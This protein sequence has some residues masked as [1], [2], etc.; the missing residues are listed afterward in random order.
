MELLIYFLGIVVFAFILFIVRK[1]AF[2]Q[3]FSALFVLFQIGFA[4]FLYNNPNHYWSDYFHDDA[5]SLIFISILTIT[6][7]FTFINSFIYF[8]HRNDKAL[9][10]SIY[11]SSLTAFFGCMSGVFLSN[12]AS[13]LWVFTEATTLTIAIL[14]YHERTIESLEATWKYVFVS[15]IGL[16]FSFIGII[17][18]NLSLSSSGGLNIFFSIMHPPVQINNTIL[19]QIAFLLILIGFSVKMGVFPLHTVCID[20]HSVAPSPVSALIST[21][22][23]NVGFIAIFRFFKIISYTPLHS[24]A[25]H[26]LYIV[27]I[28]SILYAAVYMI[29]V[30]NYKR[31]VAY[32]SIEHMGL[33]A[34]AIATGGL[35]WFAAVLHLIYHSFTK[36]SIFFQL[37]QLVHMYKTKKLAGVGSYFKLNPLGGVV[38]LMAFILILGIPPSGMFF[39]E[40]MLFKTMIEHGFLW[41]VIIITLLLTVIIWMFTKQL[42]RVLFKNISATAMQNITP[43]PWYESLPQLILLLFA[44]YL[45]IYPPVSLLSIIKQAVSY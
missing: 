18:L 4:G 14:I 45:S 37:A 19:F 21:S 39:T 31:L 26:V 15:T 9:I 8:N 27:G 12:N 23:M 13:V 44:F 29:R 40:L 10:R 7:V 11:L 3:L 5:L 1:R 22:L 16:S 28:L 2:Q 35:A 25:S 20:A 34:I 43:T 32:S 30:K 17:L 38:F 42:F 36:S 24:W 33:V 6:S 41:L